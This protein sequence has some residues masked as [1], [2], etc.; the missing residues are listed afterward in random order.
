MNVDDFIMDGRMTASGR[1]VS[2]GH[3][4]ILAVYILQGEIASLSTN[5]VFRPRSYSQTAR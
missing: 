2:F 1:R 4:N 3:E 5:A